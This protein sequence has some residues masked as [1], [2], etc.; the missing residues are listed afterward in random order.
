MYDDTDVKMVSSQLYGNTDVKMKPVA[1]QHSGS[2][3][4]GDTDV[5]MVA[6]CIFL[7]CVGNSER[8]INPLLW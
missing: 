7:G 1:W 5:K 4:H 6:S 2:Q 8:L 3:L